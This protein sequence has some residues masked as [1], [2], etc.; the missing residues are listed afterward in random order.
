VFYDQACHVNFYPT[1]RHYGLVSDETLEKAFN[2]L[3]RTE[4]ITNNDTLNAVY[5]VGVELAHNILKTFWKPKP[6]ITEQVDQIVDKHFKSVFVI[7]MQFRFWYL[8]WNDTFAFFECAKQIENSLTNNKTVKWFISA[9]DEGNIEKIKKLYPGKV[10]TASGKVTHVEGDS[11][12]FSRALVDI[13][14]LART[15]E[16]IITGGST[17]G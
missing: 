15:D 5:R 3:N 16:T 13:E 14:L 11:S 9:D 8:D 10:I 12:G 1:F 4:I 2:I 7:G 17:F 6:L